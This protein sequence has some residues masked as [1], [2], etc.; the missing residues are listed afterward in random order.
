MK[1]AILVVRTIGDPCLRQSSVPLDHVG[2]GERIL[3]KAMIETM[4]SEE[5]VGLAAPQVGVNKQLFVV[6]VGDGPMALINPK[7]VESS[8]SSVVEEGCLS[9]PNG[10]VKIERAERIVV[11]F[12]DEQNN[13][14]E[15]ECTK[16]LSRAIQ[17]ECDHLEGKLIVDY[18]TDEEKIELKKIF[19]DIQF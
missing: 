7:I 14:K 15:M 2:P 1:K 19:P 16:L 10:Y 11:K 13:Q 9:V 18:A 8:G 12:L 3:I 4:Y 6:D 5:G 17:H